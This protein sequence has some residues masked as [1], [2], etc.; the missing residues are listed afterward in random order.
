MISR[1]G[2]RST[3]LSTNY[4][5]L[6]SI[7]SI[8]S[9]ATDSSKPA[10]IYDQ[11]TGETITL[12]DPQHP[13]Y[14]DYK[15]FPPQFAQKK[16]PYLK[17][18]DQ[19]NRRNK[20]DPVNMDA[21]MYDIWSPDVYDF[22]SNTTAL[23]QIAIFFGSIFGFAGIIYYFQLNPEKPGNIKS[24][25]YDGLA[26]ELGSTSKDNDYL[27][28]AQPDTTAEE[29]C[30]ILPADKTIEENKAKYIKENEKFINA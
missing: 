30:G 23:K 28:Q 16:D 20:N 15:N 10:T 22:R 21:D 3:K 14:A 26:K 25:P 9:Y 24:Y 6:S 27:Y 1:L 19:Q 8:R 12:A 5:I 17:Y 2:L 18:D 13:E 4:R 7:K 29:E 11:T